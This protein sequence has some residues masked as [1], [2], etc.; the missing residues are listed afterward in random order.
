MVRIRR[1]SGGR[2]EDLLKRAEALRRTSHPLLPERTR[3][4]PTE[5]FDRLAARFEEIRAAKD[6]LR[7]LDRMRRWGDPFGRAYAGFLRFY[8]E[9]DLPAL[10]PARHGGSEVS[11]APLARAPAEFQIAV[12]Q[13]DDPRRLLLGY[14]GLAR[15][16]F[17]FYALHDR[18]VCTGKDPD[19]PTEFLRKQDADLPYRFERG[20]ENGTFLCTHL[21]RKDSVPWVGVEWTTAGRRFRICERCAKE[22]A[23]LLGA[24]ASGLSQPRAE[25]AFEVSCDMNIDCRGGPDCPHQRLPKVSRSLRRRYVAGRLSD[26]EFVGAYAREVEPFVGRE[27]RRLFLAGG[28]CYGSDQA[29][30]VA[31]LHPNTVERAALDRV[32]PSVEG[33]FRIDEPTASQALERLWRTHADEIVAAIEPDAAGAQR[34]VQEARAAP[35]RVS[36]LLRRAAQGVGERT[37]LSEL[38]TFHDLGA[39]ATFVDSIGRSFRV[40][41]APAAERRLEQSLPREGK[42]RGI[43]WALLLALGRNPPHAWQFSDSERRFGESLAEPARTFLE[44]P[45]A[46]YGR[47]LSA[48][49]ARAGVAGAPS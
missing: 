25:D 46:E 29:A 23:Q 13:Y 7:R 18:L 17:Y 10:L 38:P 45:A 1:A 32:L 16:G 35:G 44:A 33:V 2:E 11:Y 37:V 21:A 26:R 20:A 22:D 47:A 28:V 3:G 36:E 14:L 43:A 4:C 41:G 8:L 42:A 24:L 6:D 19:P 49:L 48:L 40:G 34:L 12:Q 9:P 15:K 39:E 30:F 5:P 31:A 27:A